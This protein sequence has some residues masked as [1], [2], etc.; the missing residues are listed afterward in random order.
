MEKK[1]FPHQMIASGLF[2][3]RKTYPEAIFYGE[4][5]L[6]NPFFKD[7]DPYH[8]PKEIND[9][10]QRILQDN[11]SISTPSIQVFLRY[12]KDRIKILKDA[13]LEQ[14]FLKLCEK[15]KSNEGFMDKY[16]N[17]ECTDDNKES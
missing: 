4:T 7:F 9:I 10:L 1:E 11:Q 16:I 2:E 3:V 6:L 12:C 8:T 14:Q 17:Y 15:Y 5:I 13:F